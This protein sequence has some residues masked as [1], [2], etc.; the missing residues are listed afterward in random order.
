MVGEHPVFVDPP[1]YQ[2][3][4]CEEN[5]WHLCARLGHGSAVIVSN[6]GRSVYFRGQ[7]ANPD[8]LIWDYHVVHLSDD[9]W[10]TDLDHAPDRKSPFTLWADRSF[11]PIP[12]LAPLFHVIRWDIYLK[13]FGSDRS[14]MK[15]N[16]TWLQPPPPWP[17]I[18]EQ[19]S[20][21]ALLSVNSE[22]LSLDNMFALIA[23][24]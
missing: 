21:P 18:G 6:P 2:P 16:D 20:L 3:Y 5:V 15:S 23:Q 24:G 17:P 8:G 9:G 12:E 10:I 7:K 11:I 22:W 14:H 1:K 19:N 4:Y 13:T